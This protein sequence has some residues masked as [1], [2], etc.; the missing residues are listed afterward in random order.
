MIVFKTKVDVKGVSGQEVTEFMLNCTDA[1]YQ[2]W[3]P[4]THLV[5][6]TRKRTA[7]NIGNLVYFDEYVG[8]HRLKFDGVV[9]DIIPGKRIIW[10]V[11]KGVPLPGWLAMEIENGPEGAMITHS[12]LVG[13]GRMGR[14]LDPFLRLYFND[15]YERTLN[16]HAQTEFPMLGE[17]LRAAREKK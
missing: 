14:M 2:R 3:W 5:F 17:R 4:G 6:H 10:Q 9:T 16:E 11:K 12:V 13:Y 7:N 15:E 8:K 1:D